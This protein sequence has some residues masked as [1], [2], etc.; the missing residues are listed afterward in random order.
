MVVLTRKSLSELL[1]GVGMERAAPWTDERALPAVNGRATAWVVSPHLL[2]AQA[3][4]A[5]LRS[6]GAKV[7]LHAWDAVVLDARA[8]PDLSVAQHV[9]AIFDGFEGVDDPEVVEEVGRMVALGGVRVAAV[10]S[11]PSASWWG[12]LVAGGA[13]DVVTM[14][15]TV[16]QLADV[17][18]RFT[19]GQSLMRPEEREALRA[20]WA[21][22]IDKL[23]E[24]RA[25]IAT[26]S[27]QQLRVLELLAAGRRVREVAELLGVSDGTVRSHVKALRN[28]LGARTQLEAVAL[29]AQVHEVGGSVTHLIP[30]PRQPSPGD[31][32]VSTPR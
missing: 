19:A 31:R 12:G 11:H 8:R 26:L 29:L 23:R 18:E 1:G 15:S 9:V 32:G 4:T 25:L 28:K 21:E 24:A 10:T 27:P 5:A 2:V 7:E 3:V 14:T 30:Q 13:V 17:V 6:V 20:A 22:A 16:A